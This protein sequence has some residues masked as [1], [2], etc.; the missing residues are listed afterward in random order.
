MPFFRQSGPY[1]FSAVAGL[2][3]G[4]GLYIL[5]FRLS[6][7]LAEIRTLLAELKE[8]IVANNNY[9]RRRKP[10]SSGY[11][12]SSGEEE[13]AFE[14][15]LAG[16]S[17]VETNGRANVQFASPV[18]V[19]YTV[20]DGSRQLFLE[21]DNLIAAGGKADY[22]K[23]H[24]LLKQKEKKFAVKAEFQWRF[25]KILYYFSNVAG[26]EGNVVKKKDMMYKAKQAAQETINLDPNCPNGQKWFAITLGC[27]GD[28]EPTAERIKN[29]VVIKKHIQLAMQLNP[30]DPTPH[31]MLGRWC[32]S[33]YMLTWLERKAA[34][35]FF[36]SPPTAT[37][38]DAI[39][40]FMQAEKLN[41]GV[42]KENTLYI[43]KCLVEKKRFPEAVA[44][45][46][47]A[48]ARP[49]E[50]DVDPDVQSEVKCL[51]AKYG[52]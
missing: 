49:E 17:D 16:F 26:E 9:S 38:E 14:D 35:A 30:K 4:A 32:Y 15:A 37:I 40:H 48:L 33:V 43:G 6:Q 5:Y 46:K 47:R 18:S 22:E 23:A 42:W 52:R 41:P 12:A 31:H 45:L 44:W 3:T 51:I 39:D 21:V 19:Q 27:V 8:E 34:A 11:S 10:K 36:G 25:A 28:Y 2:A 50:K 24:A 7:E 20:D 13:E 29:A 1:V